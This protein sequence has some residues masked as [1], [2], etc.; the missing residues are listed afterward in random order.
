M[1][2]FVYNIGE[3]NNLLDTVSNNNVRVSYWMDSWF[4]IV[5]ENY[6]EDVTDKIVYAWLGAELNMVVIDVIIDT[7]RKKSQ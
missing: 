3:Y 4:Y 5:A 1:K 7:W 2:A 6:N